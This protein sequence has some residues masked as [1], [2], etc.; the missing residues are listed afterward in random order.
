M[1]KKDNELEEIKSRLSSVITESELSYRE[2][3]E[4]TGVSLAALNRYVHKTTERISLTDVTA[5]AKATHTSAAWI[6][7]WEDNEAKHNEVNKKIVKTIESQDE[8]QKKALMEN[9]KKKKKNK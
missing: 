2:L 1:P 6:M 8:E 7:G 5:I 9:D 3:K 4:I